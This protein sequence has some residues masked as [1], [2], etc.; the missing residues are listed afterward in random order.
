MAY[1]GAG[2]KGQEESGGK[3]IKSSLFSRKSEKL[4]YMEKIE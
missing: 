2:C 4:Q 1:L 3:V